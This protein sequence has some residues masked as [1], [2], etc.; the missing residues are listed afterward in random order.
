MRREAGCMRRGRRHHRGRFRVCVAGDHGDRRQRRAPPLNADSIDACVGRVLRHRGRSKGDRRRRAAER[1]RR[2]CSQPSNAGSTDA[3]TGGGCSRGRRRPREVKRPASARP[4]RAWQSRVGVDTTPNTSGRATCH[5]QRMRMSPRQSAPPVAQHRLE[6]R[7]RGCRASTRPRCLSVPRRS[8]QSS[9]R[10]HTKM[11]R[12]LRSRCPAL[13]ATTDPAGH[14]PRTTRAWT[15]PALALTGL[16]ARVLPALAVP[17]LPFL[18]ALPTRG[19]EGPL[20][21][22]LPL[23]VIPL[24]VPLVLR[25]GVEAR[26]G[27]VVRVVLRPPVELRPF[28]PATDPG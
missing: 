27:V 1:N 13:R 20:C 17:L 4:G 8:P 3:C 15:R 22:W 23:E 19:V 9:R 12:P 10:S 2:H 14:R 25:D 24:A 7:V 5:G 16:P 6:R 18:V 21:L 26:L 28:R 11:R